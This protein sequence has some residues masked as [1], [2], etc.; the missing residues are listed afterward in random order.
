MK[1]YQGTLV[2]L[3]SLAQFFN[4]HAKTNLLHRIKIDFFSVFLDPFSRGPI[5]AF[6]SRGLIPE[7]IIFNA[8]VL[9]GEFIF[10]NETLSS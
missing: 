3:E 7:T 1:S 8:A 9:I 10:V 6:H 5:G 4:K 2:N